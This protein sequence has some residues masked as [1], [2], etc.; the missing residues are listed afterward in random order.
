VRNAVTA[1]LA[2][3][4]A[5]IEVHVPLVARQV[6]ESMRNQLAFTCLAEVMI[7]RLHWGLR[8]G[9][10]GS[11]KVADQLFLLGVNADHGLCIGQRLHFEFR[12]FFKLGIEIRMRTHRFFLASTAFF[13]T[14]LCAGSWVSSSSVSPRRTVL[15][16]MQNSWQM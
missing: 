1:E 13:R 14:R 15:G 10:T 2:C 6:I 12:D 3:I 11:G 8:M 4:A 5:G 9:I 7:E 16:S